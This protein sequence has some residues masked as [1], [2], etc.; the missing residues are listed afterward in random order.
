ME[1]RRTPDGLTLVYGDRVN[2]TITGENQN[3]PWVQ[4]REMVPG[5]GE[6]VRL[7]FF[8]GEVRR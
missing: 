3:G 5:P 4:F 6:T 2:V 1:K 8:K 7:E